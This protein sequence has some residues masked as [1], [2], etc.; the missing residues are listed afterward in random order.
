MN[1]YGKQISLEAASAC[2][3]AY[4]ILNDID[5]NVSMLNGLT[6]EPQTITAIKDLLI[7]TY[8]SLNEKANK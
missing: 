3:K 7:A 1:E 6:M 5:H 2:M 8:E 4:K